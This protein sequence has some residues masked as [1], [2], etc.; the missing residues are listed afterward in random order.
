MQNAIPLASGRM[1]GGSGLARVAAVAGKPKLLD[2][3]RAAL[4]SRHYSLRM[5]QELLGHSEVKTSK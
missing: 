2:Q 3:L 4:R 1:V 5:V